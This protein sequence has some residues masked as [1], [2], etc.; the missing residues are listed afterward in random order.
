MHRD[1]IRE[2]SNELQGIEVLAGARV[3]E[4]RAQDVVSDMSESGISCDAEKA[5]LS[6]EA[7]FHSLRVEDNNQ[8]CNRHGGEHLRAEIVLHQ[9]ASVAQ[10]VV[11]CRNLSHDLGDVALWL[12][13]KAAN[14]AWT[15]DFASDRG[16]DFIFLAEILQDLWDVGKKRNFNWIGKFDAEETF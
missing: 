12:R 10:L 8:K 11:D 13:V 16:V 1:L 7:F 9:R 3:A 4:Y 15:D 14:S 6:R 5:D 2:E